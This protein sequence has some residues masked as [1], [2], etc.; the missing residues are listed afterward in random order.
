MEILKKVKSSYYSSFMDVC[1]KVDEGGW[2]K[3]I[4]VKSTTSLQSHTTK[5]LCHDSSSGVQ[6]C[7]KR[8]TLSLW[9]GCDSCGGS[10][11]HRTAPATP[12][13]T[14]QQL[15]REEISKGGC[16]PASS[17]PHTLSHLEPLPLLLHSATHGGPFAGVLQLDHWQS[18]YLL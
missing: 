14:D 18:M 9:C 11:W 5:T 4:S 7:L 10:H 2:P 8:L 12:E 15:G 6:C 17:F 16:S 1:L 13:E 3:Q